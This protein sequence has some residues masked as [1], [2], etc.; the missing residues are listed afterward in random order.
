MAAMLASLP[1]IAQAAGNPGA[2]MRPAPMGGGFRGGTP[3]Y[4]LHAPQGA[5]GGW[6]QGGWHG[7]NAG[8][9]MPGGGT[10][11]GGGHGGNGGWHG[12]GN[13]GWHGGNGGWHGGNGSGH[14]GNGGWHGGNGGWNGGHGGWGGGHGGWGGGYHRPFRGWRMP[15]F[16]LSPTFFIPNYSYYGL[17]DPGYGNNWVR[18]YDDA[19]LVDR[20]GNVEDTVSDLD[21]DRYDRGS[22]PDY[23]GPDRGGYDYGD[24]DQVT[25]SGPDGSRVYHVA[26]GSVTT[27]I[28]QTQ[29]V[30][31][32][33]TR[34]YVE[35]KTVYV[36][37]RHRPVRKWRPRSCSCR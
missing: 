26:P 20:D 31:T 28:V 2:A 3:S 15:S 17:G 12:G 37:A 29:P 7:G 25:W 10:W 6:S 30:V 8:Q 24:D 27:V 19:V 9:P 13:G 36:K 4:G 11:A 14:G 5:P 33:T 35:E 22:V 1:A 23:P 32:T 34:T 16:F 21:W 18:Y